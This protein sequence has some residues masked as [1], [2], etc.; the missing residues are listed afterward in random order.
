MN[1]IMAENSEKTLYEKML[2]SELKKL[3]KTRKINNIVGSGSNGN[4]IKRD[5]VDA[6]EHYDLSK[7]APPKNIKREIK[8][9]DK[10]IHN[11]LIWRKED[12]KNRKPSII[13]SSISIKNLLIELE[14]YID[15]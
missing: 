4:I 5:L 9:S 2:V 3:V 1:T 10:I 14:K 6:L 11:L 8:Q 7:K 12:R 13:L 15:L